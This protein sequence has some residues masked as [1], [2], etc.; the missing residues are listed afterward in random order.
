MVDQSPKELF[1]T[2]PETIKGKINQQ[3]EKP[4]LG[5]RIIGLRD[6]RLMTKEEFD[7]SPEILYHG[8]FDPNF[9]YNPLFNYDSEEYINY[10]DGSQTLGVG[11][12]TTDDLY[13]AE[14]YS[15]VRKGL[16]GPPIIQRFL[17]YNAKM[18]DFRTADGKTNAFVPREFFDKWFEYFKD[19]CQNLDRSKLPW[20]IKDMLEKHYLHLNKL[21]STK[22]QF[23]LRVML[24][25][26]PHPVL[27]SP[28]W[29]SPPY[30]ITFTNF[31]KS[32]GFDGL[33]YIEGGEGSNRKNHNSFVFYNLKKVGTYEYWQKNK[34]T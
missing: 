28:N 10:S 15:L 14:Q 34:F 18:Y 20:F 23:D 26:A 25:T 5:E 4:P 7:Q 11:F 27:K 2:D 30:M 12:Y 29:P 6:P 31:M 33:I 32:L 17:P 22:E 9:H 24:G 3:Q 1:L 13:A 16:T 21:A 8:T 19:Y